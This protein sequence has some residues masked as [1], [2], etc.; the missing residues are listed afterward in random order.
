MTASRDPDRLIH[1][2]VV[3]GQYELADRVYDVVRGEIDAT[4]QRVVIVPWRTPDM[5]TFARLAISAAAVVVAAV[6]GI[7]LFAG[8][9]HRQTG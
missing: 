5:L 3:E 4:R 2:F 8:Q 6:I 9:R 1:A 7:N